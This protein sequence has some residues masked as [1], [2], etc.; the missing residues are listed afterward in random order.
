MKF[1]VKAIDKAGNPSAV[2]SYDWTI[3]L[4]APTVMITKMPD[5]VFESGQLRHLSSVG[6]DDSGALASYECKLDSATY[7]ACTS[8]HALTN[9]SRGFTHLFG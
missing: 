5:V 6:T 8:P 3:D 1:E 4:A 9:L 7:A 2:A